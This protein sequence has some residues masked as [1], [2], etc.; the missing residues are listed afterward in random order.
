MNKL[1]GS[2][3]R[4][5]Q[6]YARE[7]REIRRKLIPYLKDA[8]GRGHKAVMKKD[9]LMVNGKTYSLR[10]LNEKI[11]PVMR[12]GSVDNPDGDKRQEEEMIQQ[13][14]DYREMSLR[15]ANS[16]RGQEGSHCT[17]EIPKSRREDIRQQCERGGRGEATGSKEKSDDIQQ[18]DVRRREKKTSVVHN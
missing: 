4:V 1:A 6:D 2:R 7:V 18:N 12:S 17:T 8:R 9:K 13:G 10:E 3:I 15:F 14:I 11:K 5:E 16:E